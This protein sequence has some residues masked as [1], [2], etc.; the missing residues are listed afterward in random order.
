M[1]KWNKTSLCK[2]QNHGSYP[3]IL[4]QTYITVTRME[5]KVLDDG[6]YYA[7][8]CSLDDKQ[9][10]QFFTVRLNHERHRNQLKAPMGNESE[11]FQDF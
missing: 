3:I 7:R 2:N 11:D 8:I 5:T 6:S 1:W 9:A 10:V 4:G